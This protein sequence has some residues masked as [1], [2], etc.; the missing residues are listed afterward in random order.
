MDDMIPKLANSAIV[1]LLLITV[2]RAHAGKLHLLD[3]PGGRKRHIGAVPTVG[4]I[5]IYFAFVLAL[6]LD[7]H[8]LFPN[9]LLVGAMGLLVA[10]GALDDAI[11]IDPAK[12]LLFEAILAGTLVVITGAS[13]TDIGG[14]VR[15]ND[16]LVGAA[17]ATVMVVCIINA[18]NHADGVD[19]LAGWLI[20][21]A[22][23]WLMIGAALM[24]DH[25]IGGLALRLSVPVLAFLVFNSR[26]PWRHSAAV[27]MGDAG[28]LMLGYAIA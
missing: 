25:D 17:L 4:G 14:V 18:V 2:A 23:T 24:G 7:P 11:D 27:F 12:K 21:V 13:I 16:E 15:V 28:T 9:I 8:L 20:V 10:L 3:R 5:C 22:L 26:A 19:G 1:S 6:S